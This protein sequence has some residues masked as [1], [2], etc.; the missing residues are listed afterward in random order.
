MQRRIFSLGLIAILAGVQLSAL[1]AGRRNGKEVRFTVRIENILTKTGS[2][3]PPAPNSRSL[4]RPGCGLC[5]ASWMS[6][7]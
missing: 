3:P 2:P 4:S 1:A 6:G 5:T 7:F